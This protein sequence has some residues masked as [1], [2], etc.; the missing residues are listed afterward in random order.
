[1]EYE[2]ITALND[3]VEETECEVKENN[4]NLRGITQ[5]CKKK[6]MIGSL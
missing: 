6:N 5:I 3:K 4:L 2:V 1:M